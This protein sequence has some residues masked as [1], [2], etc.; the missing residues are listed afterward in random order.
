MCS[1][2]PGL[3]LVGTF[4]AVLATPLLA[5]AQQTPPLGELARKEQERRKA[6]KGNGK[7]LSNAD[8]PKSTAP[9]TPKTAPEAIAAKPEAEQKAGAKTAE[10]QHDEVWWRSRMSQLREE[11]RRNE[12][13]AEALQTRINSLS[14]DFAARD[15]PYQ[16]ARVAEDRQKAVVE[17]DRVK[18][19]IDLQKKKIIDA[20]EEARR[21]GVPPGWLR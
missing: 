14:N 19:D 9:A 3:L 5:S 4:V 17:M 12:I 1:K 13:F 8:L 2:I 11:L 10:E 20:E 16:R 15:D 18:S 7:V 21:A 6:L